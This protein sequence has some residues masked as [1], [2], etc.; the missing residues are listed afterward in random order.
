MLVL[1]LTRALY[2]LAA[3]AR[4]AA[5]MSWAENNDLYVPRLRTGQINGM[6]GLVATSKI[7]KGGLLLSI[8]RAMAL[9]V[10]EG[11]PCPFPMFMGDAEWNSLPE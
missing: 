4:I 2:T 11:G 7:R 5:M 3:A 6:R 9:A 1:R 10:H 8:P